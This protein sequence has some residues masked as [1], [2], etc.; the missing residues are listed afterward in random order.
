MFLQVT[1]YL[2]IS[3]ELGCFLAGT[4]ISS[5]GHGLVEQIDSLIQPVK[6]VFSCL[7]FAS[8]GKRNEL[9]ETRRSAFMAS[10]ENIALLIFFINLVGLPSWCL[11]TPSPQN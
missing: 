2:C 8:V 10:S 9:P 4:V 5:Q 7:F 6:D 3:M 11:G 1:N